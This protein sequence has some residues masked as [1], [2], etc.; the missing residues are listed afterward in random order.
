M[1]CW[2]SCSSAA[3]SGSSIWF[4]P[5]QLHRI[6]HGRAPLAEPGRPR[7]PARRSSSR[8]RRPIRRARLPIRAPSQRPGIA[9]S[10]IVGAGPEPRPCPDGEPAQAGSSGSAA[11]STD[12]SAAASATDRAIG[13]AVSWAGEIGTIPE[14]LIRP[15]VGLMPTT[16][17]ALAGTDD[18]AVGLGGHRERGQARR[19]PGRGPGTGAGWVPFQRVRVGGLAAQRG[20]AAG[21]V[22]GPEVRP[23]RQVGLADD[24]G[25]GLAQ[26]AHQERVAAAGV[27]QGGR[28]G[29]G[30]HPGDL[31][32]V[33]DQD[34]ECPPAGCGG[35][36]SAR[37]ASLALASAAAS[38]L[39]VMTACSAG[40]SRWIRSR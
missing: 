24:H 30:G 8:P 38:G 20:P 27:Q 36:P 3:N 28:A 15:S 16:P 34:R 4:T 25:A 37:A 31:D 17:H 2:N 32:V 6:D 29:R 5:G 7:C 39:T 11:A 33:L 35:P 14:R 23:L 1:L 26:P 18:R 19:D 40:F 10:G 9:A 13:P 12:S 21:A 22:R